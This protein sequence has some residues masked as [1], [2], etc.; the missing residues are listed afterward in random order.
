[1]ES[2]AASLRKYGCHNREPYKK[3]MNVQDGWVNG[4]QLYRWI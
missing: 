1:M 4:K 2:S 3:L